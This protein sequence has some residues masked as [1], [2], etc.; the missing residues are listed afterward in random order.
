[1]L[2][3]A[4][5]RGYGTQAHRLLAR[6]LF[7]HTPV[8]RV[9]ASTEVGNVAEQRTLEK[10]GFTREGVTRG[11]GWRD[12]AWRHRLPTACSAPIRPSDAGTAAPVTACAWRPRLTRPGRSHPNRQVRSAEVRCSKHRRVK[13][14][15]RRAGPPKTSAVHPMFVLDVPR[16]FR[17]RDPKKP[18]LIRPGN[19]NPP[20]HQT[21]GH[22]AA[23][24]PS[25]RGGSSRQGCWSGARAT[26]SGRS[27]SP[28]WLSRPDG[29]PSCWWATRGGS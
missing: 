15:E 10:A 4:R 5:G 8:H 19:L 29:L 6:Y 11:V 13:A 20:P 16:E 17:R 28:P 21:R 23:N 26:T 7:A 22:A 24:T 3:E 25:C 9:E 27:P 12:G 18:R 2:P 14:A 1:M